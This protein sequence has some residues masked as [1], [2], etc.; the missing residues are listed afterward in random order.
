MSSRPKTDLPPEEANRPGRSPEAAPQTSPAAQRLLFVDIVRAYACVMMVFGHTFNDLLDKS[1]RS[2]LLFT[3]WQHLRGLTAPTFLFVSGFAFYVATTR[4]WEDY[5]GWSP[6]LAKRL[7][8]VLWLL[9]IG[10][11]LHLPFKDPRQILHL[12]LSPAEWASWMNVDIL[13]CVAINLFTLHLIILVLRTQRRFVLYAAIGLPAVFLL[14]P[15]VWYLNGQAATPSFWNFYLGGNF[16]SNFPLVPW[17]G[18]HYAGILGGW[19]YTKRLSLDPHWHRKF[20]LAVL[21]IAAASGLLYWPYLNLPGSLQFPT[22]QAQSLGLRLASVVFIFAFV[23]WIFR[24]V[25]SVPWIIRLVGSETLT[26]Y[27]MHLIIIYGSAW[28]FGLVYH[29]GGL[30]SPLQCFAVFV[31]MFLFLTLL[32]VAKHWIM[33]SWF[34]RHPSAI[35]SD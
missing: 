18:F 11:A 9:L 24:K 31:P 13:Q 7:R 26:I 6:R 5:L 35:A 1:L 30:L 16:Y 29:F 23:S 10:Y 33:D 14:S 19:W 3:N 34:R 32:V 15:L 2:S 12:N 22:L 21:A 8:R 25:H 17:I 28:N 27:W 20:F 4:H